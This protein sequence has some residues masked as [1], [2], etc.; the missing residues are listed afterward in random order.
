MDGENR[1][2]TV[3]SIDAKT[4]MVQVLY[5][6]RDGEVTQLLPYA[7][8]N[9]EFKLPEVGSKV[10]VLHL[11]NGSE[12]GIVLGTYWNKGNPAGDPG[13]YRKVISENAYFLHKDGVLMISA[14]S[15]RM[16]SQE[17]N[18]SFEVGELL[19]RFKDMEDGLKRVQASLEAMDGRLR[20]VEQGE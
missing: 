16:E 7:T 13:D 1:I 20:R 5:Q 3:S 9:G 10:V 12:M 15:L 6:D 2:G 19:G 18:Q 14:E 17:S 4:G 8:F 11:S